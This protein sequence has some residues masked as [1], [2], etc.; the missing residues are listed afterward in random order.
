MSDYVDKS[1]N[2]TVIRRSREPYYHGA[3]KL[4][5]PH[6]WGQNFPLLAYNQDHSAT[7]GLY[8]AGE[9]YSVEGGWTEPAVR[10]ALDAVMHLINNKGSFN[11]FNSRKT[12]P[13]TR[14]GAR[15]PLPRTEGCA[16]R[17]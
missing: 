9:G 12:T 13:G 5:R 14:I 6:A 8:F 2:A 17:A 15:P 4:Y 10:S 11:N 16:G 1:A 3:A 7:S